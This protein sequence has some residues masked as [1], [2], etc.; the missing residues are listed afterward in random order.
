MPNLLV[1]DIETA[2]N[3]AYVWRLFKESIPLARLSESGEVLCVSYKWHGRGRPQ[4]FSLHNHGKKGMLDGVH[5]LLDK[6]D[7]VIH[8]NGQN[9]DIPWIQGEFVREGMGPP[10]PFQHI[11][12]LR[13][14]RSQF[15]FPSNKL[16]YVAGELLGE[17]KASHEGFELWVKCMAGDE[18]AWRTMIRYCNK[19]V[20]LTER[21]YDRLLPWIP[22]HPHV[23]LI[24]GLEL[25]NCP[26]C[27]SGNVGR[28]GWSY[29]KLGQYQRWQCRDCGKWSRSGRRVVG[30]NLR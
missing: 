27:G 19:D 3:V 6:A 1:L 13:T 9:F 5:A 14:V 21:L 26:Q 17:H 25:T 16:D 7:G 8:Y 28:N 12:L 2:P 23:G 15:R 20:A 30:A 4:N 11:D 29:T 10:S 22:G 18:A 24:D